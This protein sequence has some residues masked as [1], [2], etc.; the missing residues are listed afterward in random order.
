MKNSFKQIS[1]TYFHDQDVFMLVTDTGLYIVGS[2]D[3]SKVTLV[4]FQKIGVEESSLPLSSY[5]RER[6]F[7]PH[8]C[9]SLII[10][11]ANIVRRRYRISVTATSETVN[12]LLD[13]NEVYEYRYLSDIVILNELRVL[14]YR[15]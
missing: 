14:V 8:A 1:R 2:F 7:L 6:S 3:K 13:T 4:Y 10:D 12:Y 15:K 5:I 11:I 9:S